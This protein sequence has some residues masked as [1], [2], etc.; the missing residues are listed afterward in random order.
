MEGKSQLVCDGEMDCWHAAGLNIPKIAL[1]CQNHPLNV[2]IRPQIHHETSFGHKIVSYDPYHKAG[3]LPQFGHNLGH[4]P[5]ISQNG[6]TTA[7]KD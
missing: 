7:N 5:K 2:Q 3:H 1:K 4:Q 6:D